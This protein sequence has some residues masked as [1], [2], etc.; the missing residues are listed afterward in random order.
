[1]KIFQTSPTLVYA[2]KQKVYKVFND[3]ESCI[4][5][6]NILNRTDHILVH[7]DLK[8]DFSL[9]LMRVERFNNKTLVMERA[10]GKSLIDLCNQKNFSLVGLCLAKFHKLNKEV[11]LGDFA[12]NHLFIN[13]ADKKVEFIDPGV[14]FMIAG[15]S[16]EDIARFLFS[17]SETYRYSPKKI[18]LSITYFLKGYK[19]NSS[20]NT[21]ELNKMINFRMKRSYQKYKMQKSF[22]KSR[23]GFLILLYNRI[24]I[25]LAIMRI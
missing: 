2:I 13:E 20:I 9:E 18:I 21:K 5:E 24:I 1:M 17:L 10:Q 8:E 14:N 16:Y 12:V 7:Q 6:F 4:N 25:F 15:N 23:L 19:M 11:L 3:K 22:F